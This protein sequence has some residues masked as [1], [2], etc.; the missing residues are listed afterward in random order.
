MVVAVIV[1]LMRGL[2]GSLTT[3]RGM[4]VLVRHSE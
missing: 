3:V 1:M 4:V 2:L